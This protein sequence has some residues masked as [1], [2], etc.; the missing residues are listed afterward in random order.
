MENLLTVYTEMRGNEGQMIGRIVRLF[1][2][3]RAN[4]LPLGFGMPELIEKSIMD[5]AR[6]KF[7]LNSVSEFVKT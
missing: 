7:V 2:H 5:Y 6:T 3:I 4:W 1:V